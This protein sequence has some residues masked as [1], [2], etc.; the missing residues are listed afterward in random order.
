VG[1][2]AKEQQFHIK[3]T[4]RV[5]AVFHVQFDSEEITVTPAKGRIMADQLQVFNV[6][7][8]SH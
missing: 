1:I 6:G 8:L 3:N 7:F 2:K 5:P 4:I